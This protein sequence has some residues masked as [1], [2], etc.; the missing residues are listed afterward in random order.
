MDMHFYTPEGDKSQR[1]ISQRAVENL[2]SVGGGGAAA[3]LSSGLLRFF[4]VFA[5]ERIGLR[6]ILHD[7]I[8][9]MSGAG[10]SKDSALGQ[11]FYIVKGS[12][13][14]R[15]DVVGFR[16]Q[17]SWARLVQQLVAITNSGTPTLN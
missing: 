14:P 9:A 3:I 15:I 12:G 17:V 6:C 5:Y 1:R 11:G 8:C 4:E 13:L 7:G 16:N 2:A 10:N